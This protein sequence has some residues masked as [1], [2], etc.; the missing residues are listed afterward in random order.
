MKHLE[1]LSKVSNH[2]GARKLTKRIICGGRGEF[3]KTFRFASKV[4]V[5]LH[6]H[7][8]NQ[9]HHFVADSSRA[10]R[11]KQAVATVAGGGGVFHGVAGYDHSEY[12][13]ARDFG[14]AQSDAAQHE[15]RAGE[16]HAEPGDI[17]SDQRMDGRPVRDAAGAGITARPVARQ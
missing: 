14:G 16:L 3:E 11:L 12:R 5:S 15:V 9:L 13:G 10:V 8:L 4:V 1:L 7:K 6:R 17:H 2:F